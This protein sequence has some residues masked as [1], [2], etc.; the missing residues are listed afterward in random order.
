MILDILSTW[1]TI[2]LIYSRTITHVFIDPIVLCTSLFYCYPYC[3]LDT[4]VFP[5][6]TFYCLILPYCTGS[7]PS[8]CSILY[9]HTLLYLCRTIG[10]SCISRVDCTLW[11][12]SSFSLTVVPG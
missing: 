10:L 8:F 3:P 11:S 5:S 6:H 12:H 1:T 4:I 9:I 7:R 2:Y